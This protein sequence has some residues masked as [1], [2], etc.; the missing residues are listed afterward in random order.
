MSEPIIPVCWICGAPL[1]MGITHNRNGKTALT[2]WCAEDGRHL[3]AF[4]NHRPVVEEVVARLEAQA[5]A[6]PAL[7]AGAAPP[8]TTE[9]ALQK[10]SGGPG[11]APS[12][13]EK[14]RRAG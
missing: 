9:E 3:R 12:T 5:A 10:S 6:T 11:P 1:R 14:R 2:L 4:C 8:T 7:S 13:K